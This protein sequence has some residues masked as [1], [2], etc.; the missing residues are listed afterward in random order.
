MTN[1]EKLNYIQLTVKSLENIL[2][3]NKNVVLD[4]HDDSIH[5]LKAR[6]KITLDFLKEL[7]N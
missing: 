7:L 1:Q 6:T 2:P 4:S 5:Q 3:K